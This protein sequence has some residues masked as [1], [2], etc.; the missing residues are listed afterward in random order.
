MEKKSNE[1]IS[2]V[3]L[4]RHVGPSIYFVSSFSD[5]TTHQVSI[6]AVLNVS[7]NGPPCPNADILYG[8]SLTLF[9]TGYMKERYPNNVSFYQRKIGKF[10]WTF[11][12]KKIWI[13][14]CKE[15][16]ISSSPCQIG[17]QPRGSDDNFLLLLVQLSICNNENHF[18]KVNLYV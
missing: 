14:E 6:N 16:Q 9:G 8:W 1:I 4:Q 2:F 3:K 15:I 18:F 17:L 12:W 10:W 5:S 13:Q 11:Y 7:K